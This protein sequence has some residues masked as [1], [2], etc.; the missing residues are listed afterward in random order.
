M[1]DRFVEDV[2][3]R[4]DIVD[5]VRRYAEL[6]KTGKNY[7][8][9]SPFRKERT[10]SFCV[11]PDKQFWYD[12]GTSEGGDVISFLERIEN[13]SFLESV[14]M[15]AD[16]AGMEMPKE[17]THTASNRE[18][19]KD[20][21]ALHKKANE[22]FQ[23]QL[24]KTE[25]AQLYLSKRGI[26]DDL[27]EQWG[28]GYGGEKENG[29][30]QFLLNEGFSADLIAQS[31]VAFERDFGN[32]TM[33]D[34]FLN[35]IIIPVHEPRNG[36]IIAFTGRDIGGKSP[37]KYINSPENPVYKKSST[38]FGLYQARSAI[39]EQD[40]IV[41]VEGNFDV[42]SVHKAGIAYAV[43]T[44]GTS[45]T[46]DHL[47][48]TKRMTQNV[49]LAF[50]SDI[51]GKKATLRALEMCLQIDI[52]PFIIDIQGVKDLDDLVQTNPESIHSLLKNAP[53]ALSFLLDRFAHKYLNGSMEGKQ[54]FLDSFFEYMALIRRPLVLDEMIES[55]AQK[56]KKPRLL[57][58]QEF[59]R[60]LMKN[61]TV[62]VSRKEPEIKKT[63]FTLSQAF[64]GFLMAHWDFFGSRV[65]EKIQELFDES[66][67]LLFQKIRQGDS[68][69][70][71]EEHRLHAFQLSQ[72]LLYAH[73]VSSE[74]L[75]QD[76]GAFIE[77]LKQPKQRKQETNDQ[78]KQFYALQ[79]QTITPA[80]T[81]ENL[82]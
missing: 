42:I 67:A 80:S 35:R 31:G 52:Y 36:D 23:A 40:K 57:I 61:S 11:S 49:Y 74:R 51:A 34:R 10:P 82:L 45:L 81:T 70:P 50:D 32:Q 73:D 18:Q 33:K 79:N 8:C 44:C 15:L 68:L 19:K 7:M 63:V 48:I 26:T 1:N 58:E 55:V 78:L 17:M 20:I 25:S 66:E 24:S 41:F 38:L 72:E 14:E 6:K 71:Q 22:Y 5:I 59:Q 62:K 43:A 30:T 46:D 29:L 16:M 12:F 69:Q 53:V 60:F 64:L 4:I 2:K 9:C 21:F 54:L 76:F 65:N 39:R 27:I 75:K 77:R 56:M 28:L 47:R 3:S 37:A 13:I